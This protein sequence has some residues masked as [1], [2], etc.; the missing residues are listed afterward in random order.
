MPENK[1]IPLLWEE[2]NGG[3]RIRQTTRA[4]L[5]LFNLLSPSALR[6]FPNFSNSSTTTVRGEIGIL[7]YESIN[8]RVYRRHRSDIREEGGLRRPLHNLIISNI[9][10]GIVLK[11]IQ[12]ITI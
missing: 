4:P 6:M 10:G 2:R 11:C 12:F 5:N 1:V 3:Q 7:I 8:S 9:G